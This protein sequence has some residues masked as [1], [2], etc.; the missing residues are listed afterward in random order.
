MLRYLTI[1]V[2]QFQQNSSLV[3]CD[4]TLQAA[5][6]EGIRDAGSHITR[7]EHL[8]KIIQA[9]DVDTLTPSKEALYLAEE[10]RAALSH[11]LRYRRHLHWWRGDLLRH[12]CWRRNF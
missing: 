2:T 10:A 9:G 12:G 3:W 7:D 5:V 6:I 11:T 4:E 8:F 1:P